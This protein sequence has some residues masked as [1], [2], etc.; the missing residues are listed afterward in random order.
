[1]LFG[2]RASK[3]AAD[4]TPR[5]LLYA[6]LVA[7]EMQDISS[8]LRQAWTDGVDGEPPFRTLV[9]NAGDDNAMYDSPT[10][11]VEEMLGGISGILNEVAEE[12][13]G[14]PLESRDPELAES[15]F[16][17]TSIDDYRDNIR[18]AYQAYTGVGAW[19]AA[20]PQP[21]EPGPGARSSPRRADHRRLPACVFRAGCHSGAVRAVDRER[22]HQRPGAR[23]RNVF[24]DLADVFDQDVS[25]LLLGAPAR[26]VGVAGGGTVESCH[27][28]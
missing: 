6:S 4:L 22:R 13:I 25:A 24:A 23:A 15:R 1:M 7:A 18:G 17:E 2:D 16:S 8:T 3:R 21:A 20:R 10:A 5:E 19:H 27:S 9:V 12:K 11:V 14:L 26:P 28:G